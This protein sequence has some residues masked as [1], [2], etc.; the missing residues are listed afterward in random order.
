MGDC[1]VE[2]ILEI[3]NE[4]TKKLNSFSLEV[5]KLAVKNSTYFTENEE[6]KKK[7]QDYIENA[8]KC[9]NLVRR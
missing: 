3:M 4:V 8:E 6:G 5:A 9:I 2:K 7:V 1:K